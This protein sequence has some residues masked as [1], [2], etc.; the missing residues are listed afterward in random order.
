MLAG[1]AAGPVA[2]VARHALRDRLVRCLAVGVRVARRIGLVVLPDLLP[3]LGDETD[4][5]LF[6][7]KGDVSMQAFDPCVTGRHQPAVSDGFYLPFRP[8]TP[9]EHTIVINGHDMMDVPVTLT[10]HLTIR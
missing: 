2:Q 4:Q 5:S 3:G 7:F 8:M 1:E 9:G 6:F 10:W